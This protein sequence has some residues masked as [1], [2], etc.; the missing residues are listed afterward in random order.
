[1]KLKQNIRS[2]DRQPFQ[3]VSY[4]I[5]K[6]NNKIL[7]FHTEFTISLLT[8]IGLKRVAVINRLF[9]VIATRGQTT[10]TTAASCH[11]ATNDRGASRLGTLWSRLDV[12]IIEIMELTEDLEGSVT[13][14][15]LGIFVR[16]LWTLF[17]WAVLVW[18]RFD[19]DA[20]VCGHILW[21]FYKKYR[22][23]AMQLLKLFQIL[24]VLS[25]NTFN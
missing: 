4:I 1:M 15:D 17:G 3:M 25:Q 8:H 21:N 14:L 7:P 24:Q 9:Q 20:A 10:T 6:A 23:V 22:I 2:S 5:K 13:V 11:T 18:L 16:G 12:Q 19:F